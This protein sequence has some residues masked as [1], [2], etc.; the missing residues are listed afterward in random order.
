MPCRKITF[1]VAIVQRTQNEKDVHKTQQ[2]LVDTRLRFASSTSRSN[3]TSHCVLIT[4]NNLFDPF[5]R[6]SM[7]IN[8]VLV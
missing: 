5:Y 1:L 7:Y 2:I 8:S 3:L 4:T 6:V